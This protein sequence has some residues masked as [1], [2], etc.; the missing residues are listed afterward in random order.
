MEE[1][2]QIELTPD[3]E[4]AYKLMNESK[5]H[6]FISGKAGTGKSTLLRYFKKHT[7]KNAV[8]LAPTGLAAVNVGG[9]TIH[10]FFKFP[11]R[12]IDPSEIFRRKNRK[13]YQK[14]DTIIIDEISMVRADL[15]DS[16]DLF[17]RK[18]GPDDLAPF[19]GIQMVYIGDLFQLP[20]VVRRD[21]VELLRVQG[22]ETP[23]F[24]SAQSL[25][26]VD[27]IHLELTKVFRQTD[28]AFLSLLNQIRDKSIDF[29]GL[30]I[31]NETANKELEDFDEIPFIKL[32]STNR[33]SHSIN[34]RELDKLPHRP[35]SYEGKLEKQ[36]NEKNLPCDQLLQLKIGA[37]VMMVR[38]DPEGRWVNGTIGTISELG[39]DEIEIEVNSSGSK[40]R[41]KIKKEKWDAHKFNYDES[42]KKISSEIIGS[43]T[44]YPLKLAWAITIHKSQGMTFQQVYI[45]LG[46]GAF[47]PGQVYVALSRCVS[48]EGLIL[49]K[50]IR[51]QDIFVDPAVVEYAQQNDLL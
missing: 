23:Y 12:P 2:N 22:Y 9:Q 43:F 24:F 5:D 13:I 31:I 32:C 18:N 25:V 8:Y 20:P 28:L 29:E 15:L 48:L 1:K 19:G 45:D 39:F 4:L 27:L 49:S 3:F 44:Q 17:L 33:I 46:S 40:S 10:S 34:Q 30:E 51:P 21:H 14:L 16:I 26:D 36:F 37:Q 47:A 35:F 6:L 41:H 11:P 38:N 7:K 50:P 42:N